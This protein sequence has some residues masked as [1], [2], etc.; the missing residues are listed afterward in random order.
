MAAAVT[1]EV[2]RSLKSPTLRFPYTTSKAS[3]YE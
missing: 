2:E 1:R 3:P